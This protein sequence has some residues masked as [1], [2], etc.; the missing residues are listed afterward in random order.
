MA[1]KLGE[2]N[3]S[4]IMLGDTPINKVML[5]DRLVWD[6]KRRIFGK[7]DPN[8]TFIIRLNGSSIS[9]TSDKNGDWV[10]YTDGIKITSITAFHNGNANLKYVDFS[11]CDLSLCRAFSQI[12][13]TNGANINC[14]IRGLKINPN[15]ENLNMRYFLYRTGVREVGDL[16][17]IKNADLVDAFYSNGKLTKIEGLPEMI[18]NNTNV[19][20]LCEN[21]TTI[22]K[23]GKIYKGFKLESSPLT[24]ESAIVILDALQPV[25]TTQTIT[26]SAYTT[27]LI[28]ASNNAL[29][30]VYDAVQKG[31][32]IVGEGLNEYVELEYIESTG[33]QYIPLNDNFQANKKYEV[34]IAL[35][36]T[37]IGDT[38]IFGQVRGG[39]DGAMIATLDKKWR[40]L[41]AWNWRLKDDI[42][43]EIH[44]FKF[45]VGTKLKFQKDSGAIE[46]YSITLITDNTLAIF[47]QYPSTSHLGRFKLYDYNVQNTTTNE[48]EKKLVPAK[49]MS[50]GAIGMIDKISGQWYGNSGTG[51]FIGGEPKQD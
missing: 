6:G 50:D 27:S 25:S 10:Y 7:C 22:N 44:T 12:L 16:S 13:G 21:L 40:L 8:T 23:S 11:Y 36:T 3:I 42:D 49:R 35:T 5:G 18:L 19:L 1:I 30:K 39:S 29:A 46:T 48:V 32:T 47:A 51:T 31:W 26:F 14:D 15:I 33:T 28:N 2:S 17:N 34:K 4:K 41:A 9:V 43:T 38:K 20:H 24:L 37:E 45:D